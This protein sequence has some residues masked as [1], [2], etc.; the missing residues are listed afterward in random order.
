MK[1]KRDFV[2]N[3]SS[4]SY[5]FVDVP[6]DYIPDIERIK[7]E[8]DK[9]SKYVKDD[10][11]V[12]EIID[13]LTKVIQV[14]EWISNMRLELPEIEILDEFDNTQLIKLKGPKPNRVKLEQIYIW[15]LIGKGWLLL[16][17]NLYL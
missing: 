6:K 14:E 12:E 5:I 2:T 11:T 9:L 17:R 1:L 16:N 4:T 3:S 8:Y 13:S 15:N 10:F 7:T